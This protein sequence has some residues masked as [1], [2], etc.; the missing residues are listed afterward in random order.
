MLEQWHHELRRWVGQRSLE[1]ANVGVDLCV[2]SNANLAIPVTEAR[3]RAGVGWRSEWGALGIHSWRKAAGLVVGGVGAGCAVG[4]TELIQCGAS[5][6]AQ[7]ADV[8]G[9][10]VN[11]DGVLQA[12]GVRATRAAANGRRPIGR[13]ALLREAEVT[14]ALTI[15]HLLDAHFAERALSIRDARRAETPG[16][17]GEGATRVRE[18][19]TD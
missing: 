19:T 10:S 11:A 9:R 5:A 1:R 4:L 8:R 14:H 15:E 7:G 18:A 2:A 16:V 13:I 3:G 6:H 12:T 17:L